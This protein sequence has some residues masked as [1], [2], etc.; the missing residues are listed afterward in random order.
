MK[1]KHIDYKEICGAIHLHTTSSD[2]GVTCNEL[3]AAA[4]SVG[5][6]YIV[7]TDHMSLGCKDEGYE[8]THDNLS[9]II[10]YEHHDSN[11][12]NHYLALGVN[13]VFKNAQ[14]PQ[15]YIDEVKSS[16]GIG[17]IAH[18]MEKRHYFGSLPPNPW[19]AW[20]SHGYD[21]LEIW[22]Q[23]S[24]WVENLKSWKSVVRLMYPRRFLKNAPQEVLEKWDELNKERFV[25]GLG[26][27]DAHTRRLGKGFCSLRVFPIRVELKGIRTHL[28]VDKSLDFSKFPVAKKAILSA[29]QNGHSFISNYRRGD[30]T[31]TKMFIDYNNGV[32]MVP[33]L[34]TQSSIP[35]LITVELPAKSSI[36]LIVNGQKVSEKNGIKAEFEVTQS[37][38]YR[39]EVFR[40]A[41]AWIYSNPFPVGSYPFVKT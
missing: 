15:K 9:V 28:Y 32:R 38:V 31:G 25:S 30:A 4:Q 26:G 37:G 7:V 3:I 11:K 19:L 24:E 18:P 23:M 6:D 10:G 2:G 8:G 33:G 40:N 22:N 13:H 16:G 29:L 21:G 17:F 41:K 27:V 39:I 34:S 5:I 1:F 14:K 35:A 12:L 20:D 36:H